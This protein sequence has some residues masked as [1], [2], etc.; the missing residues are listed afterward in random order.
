MRRT[1]IL[2]TIGPASCS[3]ERLTGLVRAGADSFRLNFSHG[4]DSDHRAW[5]A[6][7]RSVRARLGRE[8]PIVGDVQGPKI[9]IGALVPDPLRLVEGATWTLDASARPGN[10]R[11]VGA[12]APGLIQTARPGDPILLGDGGVELSV[13][14]V[15]RGGIHARVVHGGPVRSHAG[16]FLPRARLRTR[17]LG[18]KDLHD[19]AVGVAGGIDFLAVSF[20]RDGN[21]MR[22]ARSALDRRPGGDR[23]GLIAKIER[24]EALEAIDGILAESDA[25]MVARGDLG[26]ELPLERLALAQ[27]ALVRAANIAARPVIVATQM[28]LSMV[29]APRPTR[30]EATDVANAVLDGADA[31][32][33][34]EESAI[35]EYPDASVRWLARIASATEGD[36]PTGPRLGASR[37]G[38]AASTPEREL[39][40]AAVQLA[41]ALD[42]RAIITPTHSGRTA[43]LVASLRP[44]V[45]IIALCALPQTRRH[46][47][48][49]WGVESRAV[50]RHQRLTALRERA[51]AIAGEFGPEPSRVILTAG[52]PVE[53]R[54]T[55]LLTIVGPGASARARAATPAVPSRRDG[56]GAPSRGTRRGGAGGT[57]R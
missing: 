54:P 48:L 32:M 4:S 18:P 20:V 28:L 50:P 7:M 9:R 41:H 25:I 5:L 17:I 35:G 56:P 53:G 37:A 15:D 2:V 57:R 55:N 1:K 13:T 22:H 27:K 33:L 26:I 46:L 40:T 16:L 24:A 36:I 52:Y 30:A 19:L 8:L 11:R 14:R 47:G 10:A 34:S 43:T 23:V 12:R 3:E 21:D 29:H 45:P 49:V 38:L 31:V 44:R 39:A 51:L 42:A 6:R